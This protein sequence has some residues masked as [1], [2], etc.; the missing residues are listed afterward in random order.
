MARKMPLSRTKSTAPVL[1][2][3][4]TMMADQKSGVSKSRSVENVAGNQQPHQSENVFTTYQPVQAPLPGYGQWNNWGNQFSSKPPQL[5]EPS[6]SPPP[7]NGANLHRKLQRQL[8]LNPNFDPRLFQL[9]R[10]HVQ[11]PHRP[12]GGRHSS[13]GVQQCW[14]HPQQQQQQQQHQ[15][16]SVTRIA[17][18]PDTYRPWPHA[19]PPPTSSRHMHRLNSTSDP[20]LNLSDGT[21]TLLP[22][23]AASNDPFDAP[24]WSG[25]PPSVVWPPQHLPPPPQYPTASSGDARRTLHYHLAYIFP[26]EQVQKAMQLY[27]DET[28]P[29]KICAAIL[30]MFPKP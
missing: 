6:K 18:A 15:H 21:P 22:H 7:D 4:P 2:P 26:E 13:S 17:S 10:G 19:A 1:A 12:L 28:N 27:P 30:N 9:R 8:T 23:N 24:L 20:Q 14:D 5:K 11:N 3:P 29:Q 16:Q 25:P